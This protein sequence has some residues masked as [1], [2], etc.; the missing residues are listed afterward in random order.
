MWGADQL[1][2]F[3]ADRTEPH[4]LMT[5]YYAGDLD[6]AYRPSISIVGTREPTAH[7]LQRAGRL[8]RELSGRGVIVVSGLAKGIDTAAHQSALEANGRTIAVIGTPLSK[9]SPAENGP[10][11]ETIW[12][13][14][15]LISPFREGQSVFRS[16]FP[17][18]NQ[19]MAAVS[20]GTVIV[21]ANDQSG[22]LHQAVACQKLGRWLF[23]LKSLVDTRA[24]PRRFTN[25]RNTIIL[26]HTDQIFE[27]LKL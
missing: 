27:A 15:L 8:S 24:W 6:L 9:A 7:G 13:K 12:R 23:I 19:V 3:K 16:N 5:L 11:Q 2:I 25:H 20:D 26:E 4:D 1:N 21:E 22:T 18:R 17:R 10:L 14:H